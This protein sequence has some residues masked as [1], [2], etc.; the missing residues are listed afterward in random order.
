M[1]K[2]IL[3]ELRRYESAEWTEEERA[4]RWRYYEA[5]WQL[6]FEEGLACGT[7]EREEE[8]LYGVKMRKAAADDVL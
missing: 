8:R 3:E 5:G 6:G 4:I 2:E 7:A 1:S